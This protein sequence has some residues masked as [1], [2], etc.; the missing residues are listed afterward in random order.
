MPYEE[1]IKIVALISFQVLIGGHIWIRLNGSRAVG[2]FE[3]FGM[4]FAFGTIF[5][6]VVDQM[7]VNLGFRFNYAIIGVFATMLAFTLKRIYLVDG[8]VHAETINIIQLPTYLMLFIYLGFGE[9]YSGSLWALLVLLGALCS[10]HYARLSKN[11]LLVVSIF[12]SF[13]SL[14][15]YHAFKSPILYGNW[16]LR[17]LY[18][19]T[20]DAIFSESVGYSI[21]HFGWSEYAAAFGTDIRYHWFSLAWSGLVQRVTN[22]SPFTMTLHV[23]PAI[24]FA[25]IG[26]LLISIGSRLTMR[27][28]FIVFMPFVLFATSSAPTPIRFFYV[29]NTS[30]VLPVVW[31]LALVLVIVVFNKS[32]V[33][34]STILISVLIGVI[35]LSKI[36]YAA[37]PL[38][39]T[40]GMIT[41][42][43][44]AKKQSLKTAFMQIGWILA[45]PALVFSQFLSPNEWE[46]RSFTIDW[47][48]MNVAMGSEYRVFP[49]LVLISILVATRLPLLFQISSSSRFNSFK[50]FLFCAS[51][52]GLI[53]FFVDGS[54]AEHYFLNNA[55]V[56]G[57]VAVCVVLAD[58]DTST[59]STRFGLY[60]VPGVVSLI[61]SFIALLIWDSSNAEGSLL[62]FSILQIAIPFVCALTVSLIFLAAYG[63][64]GYS[65]TNSLKSLVFVVC[66]VLGSVGIFVRQS[67]IVPSYTPEGSVATDVEIESLKWLNDN[68]D[69][70]AIIAT[71]RSMCSK[72]YECGV[73]ESSYLI[74]AVA[75]RRVL[76]EGPRFVTGGKPYPNWVNDRIENSLAFANSPSEVS[77]DALLGRGITWFFLDSD[78]LP[79]GFNR[80]SMPWSLWASL[81][82]QNENI[83]IFRLLK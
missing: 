27:R 36:P 25:A 9:L 26:A 4:G 30:N 6:T 47:N 40:I 76:I 79:T 10:T 73:D 59:P 71:N 67:I 61:G 43:V 48:L 8:N 49:A 52:T 32:E 37:A 53:R 75:H 11:Q 28:R 21:S 63:L 83:Y 41:Y 5:F 17:P 45:I 58:L 82:Y 50:V 78:L 72:D 39:G 24:S 55:L 66:L 20:D 15:V 13:F 81:E 65:V 74:S 80:L 19:G 54:S 1:S 68:S 34:K 23:V 14:I 46:K 62:R 38:I 69:K 57:S 31:T 70:D 42:N 60:F 12:C 3:F 2:S 22:A 29:L 33:V 7:L 64:R 56:Y 18:I 77:K 44:F 51:L 35:I 16:F